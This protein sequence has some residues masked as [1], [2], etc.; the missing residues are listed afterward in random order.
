MM[1]ILIILTG[2]RFSS[3]FTSMCN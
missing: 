3:R 1:A 2:F